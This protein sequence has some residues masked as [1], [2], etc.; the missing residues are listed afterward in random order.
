[1]SGRKV[2]QE[3]IFL[4]RL[5]KECQGLVSLMTGTNSMLP[6]AGSEKPAS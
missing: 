2:N 1:M 6:A 5:R 4:D 3:Q